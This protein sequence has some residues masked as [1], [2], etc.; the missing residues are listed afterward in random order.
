MKRICCLLYVVFICNLEAGSIVAFLKSIENNHTLHM[1]YKG[2]A[3]ICKSYGIETV[4]ELALRIDT[5]SSCR[6]YI[7]DFRLS[8]PKEEFF[9]ALSLH[10]EQ[11]YSVEGVDNACLLHLSS[12]HSYSEA[13]LENGYARIS[14]NQ[15]SNLS[16]LKHRFE[17]AVKRAKNTRAGMWSDIN[18]RNCFLL[19]KKE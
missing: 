13:L 1:S 17:K 3:F 10:V 8:N 4:G 6:R 15:I 9:G 5:N 14:P 11:Q 7:D 18:I 16:L 19:A 2:K 12:G